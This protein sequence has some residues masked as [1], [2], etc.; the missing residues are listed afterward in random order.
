VAALLA[1]G[2]G[3]LTFLPKR[4]ALLAAGLLALLAADAARRSWLLP[5]NPRAHVLPYSFASWTETA[6]ARKELDDPRLW[7]WLGGVAGDQLCL[8]DSTLAQVGIRRASGRASLFFS[9]AAAPCHDEA[10]DF[11]EAIS[12]LR[13]NRVRLLAINVDDPLTDSW[14][15]HSPFFR[16]LK[17]S[18]PVFT[19]PGLAIYDLV[20]LGPGADISEP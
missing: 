15:S 7:A 1:A 16:H 10:L 18:R 13:S 14:R 5:S 3:T 17:A 12:R 4:A 11:S 19:M 9:P 20:R 6:A 8:V 2:A